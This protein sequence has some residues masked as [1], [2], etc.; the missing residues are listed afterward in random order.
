MT[1]TEEISRLQEAF[2]AVE[3]AAANF[4]KERF[5]QRPENGKWSVAENIEHLL[6][7]SKAVA[8]LLGK[9]EFMLEKWGRHRADTLPYETWLANYEHKLQ[10]TNLTT[11][12]MAPQDFPSR[13]ILLEN[14]RA[15][16]QKFLERATD[17]TEEEL[18]TYQIPHPLLGLLNCRE[19]I[20]F[21]TFHELHHL[22]AIQRLL[23]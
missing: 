5:S 18:D 6:L 7:T 17:M 8:S 9:P 2:T 21:T 3:N 4:P 13:E 14:L 19:F 23:D 12:P 20:Y 11:N 22:K 1:K 10:N 16:H 15:T